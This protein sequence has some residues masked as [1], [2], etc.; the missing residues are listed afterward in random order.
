MIRIAPNVSVDESELAFSFTRAS[1]PG[2]QNV[3]RVQTAVELRFDV[4]HSPGVP[5]SVAL[6]LRA[7]VPHLVTR[8]GVVI[9]QAQ[10]FRTQNRN[11]D[12][13][14]ERLTELLKRA[15]APPKKRHKTRP[16]R[17]SKE[18]RIA[19]KKNRSDTKKH[20]RKP[21]VD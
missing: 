21:T 1:G 14:V 12:D 19:A 13:A 2:G 8:D 15:A 4:R 7:L 5:V 10:R 17:A 20:R 18:R 16:T 9:I 3:N 11:R 6:R